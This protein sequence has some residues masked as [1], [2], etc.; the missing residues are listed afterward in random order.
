[1]TKTL[2]YILV[3]VGLIGCRYSE[4]K[5]FIFQDG[6]NGWAA[7]VFNCKNGIEK[8]VVDDYVQFEIPKNGILLCSFSRSKGILNDR[9]SLKTESGELI[10]LNRNSQE[11]QG[12]DEYLIRGNQLTNIYG[13]DLSDEYETIFLN[14]SD[15]DSG[16]SESFQ[17]FSK[18]ISKYLVKNKI[19]LNK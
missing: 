17:Q 13:K 12:K 5:E 8:N 2:I 9:F 18:S 19:E 10:S 3:I 7:V 11:F 1:M 15:S 16:V 6:Y 4:K 14:C